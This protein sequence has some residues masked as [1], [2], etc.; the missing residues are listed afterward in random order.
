[1]PTASSAASGSLHFDSSS[2]RLRMTWTRRWIAI[3]SGSAPPTALWP[4]T[5]LRTHRRHEA[6]TARESRDRFGAR[7]GSRVEPQADADGRGAG[8]TGRR[9]DDRDDDGRCLPT[10][11]L[12]SVVFT[13]IS[14]AS[15]VRADRRQPVSGRVRRDG[16]FRLSHADSAGRCQVGSSYRLGLQAGGHRFDPGTLHKSLANRNLLLSHWAKSRP[17]CTRSARAEAGRTRRKPQIPASLTAGH[18]Y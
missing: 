6:P 11:P 17:D 7:T 13:E 4:P 5:Q 14:R 2:K 8:R 15:V 3:W 1:M 10:T 16:R 9:R 12:D 18:T